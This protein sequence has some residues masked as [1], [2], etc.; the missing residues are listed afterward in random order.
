MSFPIIFLITPQQKNLQLF[1]KNRHLIS[2][3][4]PSSVSSPSPSSSSLSSPLLPPSTAFPFPFRTDPPAPALPCVDLPTKPEHA[5]ASLSNSTAPIRCSCP[6]NCFLATLSCCSCNLRSACHSS[7]TL[8]ATSTLSCFPLAPDSTT[9]P[10]ASVLSP[11]GVSQGRLHF[12][13][14]PRQA[15]Q[16]LPPSGLSQGSPEKK[17]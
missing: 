3:Y 14:Q 7:F 12:C 6:A 8:R 5:R 13:L 9:L 17:S 10:S 16:E 4:S 11:E 1:Y 15:E 2:C